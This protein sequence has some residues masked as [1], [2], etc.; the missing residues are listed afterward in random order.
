[1]R[2]SAYTYVLYIHI[3]TK[4][5][6]SNTYSTCTNVLVSIKLY[7]VDKTDKKK[8]SSLTCYEKNKKLMDLLKKACKTSQDDLQLAENDL[9]ACLC[10]FQSTKTLISITVKI[11]SSFTD[12]PKPQFQIAQ[13]SKSND[14]TST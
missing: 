12:L 11:L 13:V 9:Y 1:M 3:H 14:I 4:I 8:N 5:I 10:S 6:Q 2:A 7:R